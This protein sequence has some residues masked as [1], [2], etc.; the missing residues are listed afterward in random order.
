[1]YFLLSKAVH[2]ADGLVAFPG[3]SMLHVN[4]MLDAYNDRGID[5]FYCIY[6]E[7]GMKVVIGAIPEF[8]SFEIVGSSMQPDDDED[9]GIFS[10]IYEY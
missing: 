1:M 10:L 2:D 3:H 7:V 8:G 4:E 5:T 9:G 6:G